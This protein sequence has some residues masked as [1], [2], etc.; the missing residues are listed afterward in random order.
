MGGRLKTVEQR[1][2]TR[3]PIRVLVE[4]QRL[5]DFL[6][7]YTANVS[8]GGMFIATRQPLDLGTRFRLRF[9]IPDRPRPVETYGEVRWVVRPGEGPEPGMGIRFDDLAPTDR[10]AVDEWLEAWK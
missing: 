2:H 7:D 8:L 9:R 6:A 1:V 10:R 5:D 3:I 4:Y